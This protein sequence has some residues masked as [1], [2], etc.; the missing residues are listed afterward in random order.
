MIFQRVTVSVPS[1]VL[2]PLFCTAFRPVLGRIRRPIEFALK[3]PLPGV[4][5]QERKADHS[6]LSTEDKEV[7]NCTSS[8]LP[9]SCS[10]CDA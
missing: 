4:K 5:Q 1:R 7:W 9:K 10:F 6:L 3:S 8:P 2:N